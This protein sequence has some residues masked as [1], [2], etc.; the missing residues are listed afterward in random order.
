M[1][2]TP[3]H[4]PQELETPAQRYRSGL[5]SLDAF[6]RASFG[7]AFAELDDS[8]Q[9]VV[10]TQLESGDV[11]VMGSSSK[12]FFELLLLNVR[13]GYFSDPM[14]GGNKGMAGWKMIGFPGA[15]YDFRDVVEK[16]GETLQI[17]PT[18]MIDNSL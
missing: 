3:E 5:A 4:G 6:C 12:A 9:D 16:R 14:Y 17:I 11:V 1:P 18:S 13:E 10:I 7:S 8:Q 15:R 2:G